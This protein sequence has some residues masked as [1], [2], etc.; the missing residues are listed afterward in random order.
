VPKLKSLN[1]SF[2]SSESR[3]YFI[4]LSMSTMVMGTS[5]TLIP[6]DGNRHGSVGERAGYYFQQGFR[7]VVG[8]IQTAMLVANDIQ[9]TIG[10]LIRT[11]N[12]LNAPVQFMRF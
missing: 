7:S 4:Q 10:S 11:A 6:S 1:E 5:S 12:I 3:K 8:E 2:C 9:E